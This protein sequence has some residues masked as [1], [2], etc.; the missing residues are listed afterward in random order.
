MSEG[1][2]P[3]KKPIGEEGEDFVEWACHAPFGKD[4]LFRGQKYRDGSNNEIELCDLLLL[5]DDTAVLMEVK[6]ADREKRPNRTDE[7]WSDWANARLKKAL[8]QIDRGVKAIRDG[9]VKTIENERQGQVPVDAAKIKHFY[10]I[11][12]VDHPQ[13]DKFGKGPTIDAGGVP[14]SV[15]TT[16]HAELTDL[17]TE[18]ST[19]GDLIDYLQAR[20][21]FF[22]KNMLM[23]ITELDLLAVYKGDPDEFRRNVADHDDMI[24]GK[25]C[26]EEF[27]KLEARQRRDEMDHPSLLVD[28]IIDILHEGRHATL[29]HVEERRA[30]VE[31]PVD[32]REAYAKIA[33]ELAKIRRIDRRL[34]GEGLIE[35]S[36]KC[37]EQ[38]RDRW[39][40]NSPMTREGATVVFMVS[41]SS[42]EERLQSLEMATMGALLKCNVNRVVGI[43]TEPV[44]GGLGFSVDAV[45]IAGEPDDFRKRMSPDLL[46]HLLKKFGEPRKPDVTEF[47]GPKPPKDASTDRPDGAPQ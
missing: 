4:F 22:K 24:I 30:R 28:A 27:S 38:K 41:T 32:P 25:G 7:E 16:T 20:E 39:F 11:A 44:M 2:E 35:K 36:K 17:L 21:A 5:L 31:Q 42:R 14:V 37:I 8:S 33:A 6:T 43:V 19:P 29:P 15:L 45:M 34:I 40:A 9:L 26:W 10:G 23:G 13:L 12:I 3:A 46:N 47:G 1:S 18:L